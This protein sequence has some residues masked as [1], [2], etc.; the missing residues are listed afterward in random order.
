MIGDA[1]PHNNESDDLWSL[2]DHPRRD[3]VHTYHVTLSGGPHI[4]T[5]D[6]ARYEADLWLAEREALA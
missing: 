6:L 4:T 3:L 2:L 5:D 1:D